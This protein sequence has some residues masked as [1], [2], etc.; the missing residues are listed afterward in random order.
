MLEL[1]IN[2][3]F[4]P[5]HWEIEGDTIRLVMNVWR[6]ILVKRLEVRDSSRQKIVRKFSP[7]LQMYPGDT[8]S[9]DFRIP[10]HPELISR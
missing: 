1:W 4:M 5:S 2:R 8:F 10:L 7:R 6:K 3:E 9:I